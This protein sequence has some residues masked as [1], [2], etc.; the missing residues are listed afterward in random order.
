MN[1]PA[2]IIVS[3]SGG[4][5]SALALYELLADHRYEVVALLTSVAQSYRR[6]SHHGVREELLVKQAEAIGLP[7]HM[8]YLPSGPDLLCTNAI[9]EQLMD[10]AL[11]GFLHQGVQAVAFGDIFLEDLRAYRERNLARLGLV[12]LFP[13]WKRNTR[14]LVQQF[15]ELGFRAWVTCVEG[16]LGLERVGCQLDAQWVS[17]LPDDCD[18]CGENGEYHSFVYDGPLFRRALPVVATERIHREGRY[19]AELELT[20]THGTSGAGCRTKQ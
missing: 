18:P 11:R 9:Y 1:H 13:L 10:E 17:A 3:W 14:E 4:K 6:I 16:R 8:V 2:R 19:Y 20:T 7:L 5:D 15:M 12:G